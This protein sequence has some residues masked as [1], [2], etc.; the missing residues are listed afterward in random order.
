VTRP[1]ISIRAATV[2]DVSTLMAFLRGLAEF[3]RLPLAT[4][5]DSLRD[6]LF[7]DP[8]AAQALLLQIDA[9]PVGY[10]LFFYTF[11]SMSGKRC[12]WLDDLFVAPEHRGKGVGRA[13]MTYLARLAVERDCARFEWIVLDWNAKAISFYESLGATILADWRVC[14]VTGP[15]LATLATDAG[16]V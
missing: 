15:A 6:A 13:A 8:P 4:T 11:A 14:R 10:A 5:E 3:E 9:Q 1:S 12:L 2:D 7:G 16:V